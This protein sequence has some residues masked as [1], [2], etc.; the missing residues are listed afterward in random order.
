MSQ[1]FQKK[2]QELQEAGVERGGAAAR[3]LRGLRV[4]A[5]AESIAHGAYQPIDF[6]AFSVLVKRRKQRVG[7][8]AARDARGVD[9]V[10][11]GLLVG[12]PA[13]AEDLRGGL[14][15]P[16]VLRD[17]HGAGGPGGLGAI[18]ASG[19]VDGTN[20]VAEVEARAGVAAVEDRGDGAA[21]GHRVDGAAELVVD[22]E[23]DLAVRAD[24]EDA[25]VESGGL[26][27][28]AVDREAAVAAVVQE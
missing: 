20:G 10:C 24:G 16:P 21:G 13:E 17:D 19:P 27:H 9:G 6:G 3:H 28:V 26:V 8:G 12:A 23:L 1:V 4:P 5:L 25:R 18:R 14:R 15:V 2:A 11:R 22:D 7:E